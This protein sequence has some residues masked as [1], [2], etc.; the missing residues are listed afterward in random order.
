MCGS[1][2]DANAALSELLSFWPPRF[3]VIPF[4]LRW[5][6]GPIGFDV[7][8]F[9]GNLLMVWNLFFFDAQKTLSNPP[10][11]FYTTDLF[12]AYCSQPG[13]G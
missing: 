11:Y 7:G 3:V 5:T 13:H 12:Q 1:S 4:L 6:V 9:I 2:A 10:P 8:S